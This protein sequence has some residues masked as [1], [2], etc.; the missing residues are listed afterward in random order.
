MPHTPDGTAPS[1]GSGVG[2]G[3]RPKLWA[4]IDHGSIMGAELVVGILVWG[5]IGFLLDRW[6]GT[7]PWLLL[8]GTFVG[9]GGGLYLIW[10]RSARMERADRDARASRASTTG[11]HEPG[12]DGDR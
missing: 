7:S 10:V 11:D 12:G 2:D 8:I 5:G 4:D 6:L 3:G 1:R 9:F